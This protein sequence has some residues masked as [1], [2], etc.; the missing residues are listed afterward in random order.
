MKKTLR[1]AGSLLAIGALLTN[2]Q[3]ATT[4]ATTT[5]ETQTAETVQQA[6]EQ[7]AVKTYTIEEFMAT[8][9]IRG[10]AISPDNSKVL[11]SSNETGIY[12]AF[13]V[14]VQ[15]GTP[16][17][18]TSSKDNSVF[19]IS[20]FPEDERILYASDQ[21]GNEITH[22]YVR[23]QDGTSRDLTPDAKAKS[24]FA[25]WSHDKKSFFYISNKRDPKLFDLY[26]MDL[27]TLQPRLVFKNDQALDVSAISRDK[28]YIGLVKSIT[29]NKSDM[30]LY[31]T[32]T[33]KLKQLSKG[34]GEVKYAPETFTPDGKKLYFLTDEGREYMAVKSYDLATGKTEEVEQADWDIMYTYFSR[35]GKYRVTGINNDARSEIKMY[36]VATGQPV[37]L[38]AMPAGDITGIRI[39]D[40]ESVM[41]FTVNSSKSPNNLFSYTFDN[42]QP[43]QLTN[44]MNPNIDQ[45]DLVEGEVVRYKSFDGMEIPALLYKPKGIKEGEKRPAVLWI[46]GGPGGQTR[47]TYSPLMQYVINHGYVLLAVNNRG[48][49]GYGKTFFAAD[50]QKHGDADLKDCIEAKSF[51]ASTGYVDENKIGIMGGSYGG[52]MV[53]AGLAFAPEE[54]A[55]GVDIFGVANWLRT[56][57]S[58]P[59]WWESF[60]VALY[61]EMGNP[62]TDSAALY[63]KSPLFFAHQIK[64][65]LIVL[66]GANDPRVLKV[67][68]DEIVAAVKKNNVPVEYVVFP[69]EGHGFVKKENEIKGYRAILTFLDTHLKGAPGG[70]SGSSGQ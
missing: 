40:D 1:A 45:D 16:K 67:E 42:Q 18:L 3:Q 25:D 46:H 38:P 69:D 43:K 70:Q 23:N 11:Y 37:Q 48:S 24:E 64:R 21:G 8:T 22:L 44:T 57:Q 28:R 5:P 41:V 58:I 51:L 7:P 15:G 65:P 61:K 49:S 56:L 55:V 4:T 36:E 62:K 17:Q 32:K 52:Y 30:Y 31:D 53:L 60:R 59:P 20:Y 68:S 63:N 54:F 13:E 14:P 35:N 2:C 26:E 39:S 33:K 34:Q 29:T 66:Q 47:L 19:V 9:S 6:E 27:K 10:N 50:D 12:N